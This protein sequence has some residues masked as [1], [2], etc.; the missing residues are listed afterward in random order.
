VHPDIDPGPEP[1]PGYGYE[2]LHRAGKPGW[3]RPLAGVIALGVTTYVVAPL[4]AQA[5]LAMWLASQ[6]EPIGAG[7]RRI[8]DLDRPTPIGLAVV[9][10]VLASGILAVWAVTRLLHGLTPGWVA[11]VRPGIRWRFLSVCLGLAVVAL[12]A[13]VVVSG[14]LSVISPSSGDVDTSA[15]LNA[16]TATTRDF[17][18]VVLCLTPLQAAGEE[19]VFRGY[20]THAVGGVLGGL[21]GSRL[22]RAAAVLIPAVLFALAHGLGQSPPV[23]VDRLVFGVIAG[24]LVIRTGGLEAGIAMHVLNNW[25]AFGF[26]LAFGDMAGTLTPG[27]GRWL[28]LI[29]TLVQSLAYLG[30]VVVVTR[31]LGLSTRVPAAGL[32]GSG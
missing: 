2:E 19:Y 7:I 32:V 13:T 23:F 29:P 17:A 16:F 6:G 28:D 1:G 8:L 11:S 20:L 14:L 10:L 25:L 15:G 9:N 31:R 4:L 24:I 30:L 5:G 18:L 12:C 22:G 3:W 27:E 26:A 21:V